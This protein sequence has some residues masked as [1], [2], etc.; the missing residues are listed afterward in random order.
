MTLECDAG[1]ALSDTSIGRDA[2][3]KMAEMRAEDMTKTVTFTLTIPIPIPISIPIPIPI[4]AAEKMAEMRAEDMRVTSV[5][6]VLEDCLQKVLQK[7]LTR[8]D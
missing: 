8:L 7:C 5:W 4:H 1:E 3:E 2:A 6:P